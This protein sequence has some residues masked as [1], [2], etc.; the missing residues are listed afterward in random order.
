MCIPHRPCLSWLAVIICFSPASDNLSQISFVKGRTLERPS[1]PLYFF[2]LLYFS[3]NVL[4]CIFLSPPSL[5]ISTHAQFYRHALGS[6]L[7]CT[8][9][10]WKGSCCHAQKRTE[11]IT[12][13]LVP[14]R[15]KLDLENPSFLLLFSGSTCHT[16]TKHCWFGH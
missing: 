12:L 2:D 11:K 15:P 16:K 10:L 8:Q 3:S 5:V 14:V 13:E 7:K 1:F 4:L 9:F 6:A